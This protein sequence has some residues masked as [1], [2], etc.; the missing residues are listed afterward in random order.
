MVSAEGLFIH[1]EKCKPLPLASEAT[2]LTL[3]L[4][5]A[6][7]SNPGAYTVS[8][9]GLFIHYEKRKPSASDAAIQAHT[10]RWIASSLTPTCAIFLLNK[11]IVAFR[12]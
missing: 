1:Y 2:A 5:T 12:Q 11:K 3:S 4:R 7:R 6:R 8:A 9:E 10:R